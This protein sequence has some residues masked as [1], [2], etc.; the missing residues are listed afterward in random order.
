MAIK[1]MALMKMIS[2]AQL[3]AAAEAA[4]RSVV[5]SVV[6]AANLTISKRPKEPTLDVT[7]KTSVK[8]K[9]KLSKLD[10]SG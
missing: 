1:P 4:K 8:N 9:K 3:L 6:A 7:R 10:Q 2:K 5:A